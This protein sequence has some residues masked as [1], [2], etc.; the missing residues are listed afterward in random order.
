MTNE[1]L[2]AKLKRGMRNLTPQSHLAIGV[3]IVEHCNLNCKQCD[4]YST[5]AEEEYLDINS[6]KKD[7]ERLSELF[8]G[9]MLFIALLGGEPLLNPQITEF[10]RITREAFPV[11]EIKIVTNGVLLPSMPENFWEACKIYDVEISPTCYPIKLD[12]VGL[13]KL[14]DSKG[15]KYTLEKSV[16]NTQAKKFAKKY[17]IY[18]KGAGGIDLAFEHFIS[19]GQAVVC[20]VLKDGKMY[21][22]P[23]AAYASHLKKYFNLDIQLSGRDGVDIYS[24]NSGYELLEKVSRPIPFCAYCDATPNDK[25]I[26]SDW[27]ISKKD[28]YEWLAF[29][30]TEDDMQYLKLRKPIVYVFGAGTWGNQTVTYLKENGI[31]IKSVLVTRKK[32][33]VDN[34]QGVPIVTLDELREVEPNSICLVALS[35]LNRE[36][37]EEVYPLLSE[38]GF[39][40]VVPI[41]DLP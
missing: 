16:Q 4:H 35:I 38:I 32:Q 2:W 36:H 9:E 1:E 31:A 29:S 18:S 14:A 5:L 3:H 40:D 23:E 33:D 19:C 41:S 34:I 11:G 25:A 8:G 28:R 7:C 17:S 12:Y 37:K 6:Y 24:V 15:V 26:T 22:C 21:P 39:G 20:T 10:M 30:F 13:K 27:G